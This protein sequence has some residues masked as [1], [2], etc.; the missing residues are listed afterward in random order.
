[1]FNDQFDKVGV[2]GLGIV[3]SR[4]AEVLRKADK[5]VYVWNRSPKPIPNFLSSPGELA[6]LADAIQIFVTNGEALIDVISKLKDSLTKR[7]LVVNNST[8]DPES[9]IKAAAIVGESGASFLDA[10]FTGSKVAAEKG[11]LVYYVGGEP[12]IAERAQPLLEVTA[13]EALF[14]GKVG[15]ASVLKIATN[16]ISAT[17]VHAL[18]EAYALTVR[19]GIEPEKLGEALELNA[20]SSV[21]T[22]MKLP[23]IINRD[24]DPHFSLKNMFKDA[25]F[26]MNLANQYQLD[27]PGI[28]T[29]ASVMFRTMQKGSGEE[30]YS[31]LAAN[32]Q[33]AEDESGE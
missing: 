23:T 6:Q 22:G 9:A 26:A 1:M 25:Q 4:V 20:C 10:P 28:S 15:D 3:G 24:Y 16:L 11:A 5:H 19:A 32:Y 2:I 8:V 30:D 12:K 33:D 17:T 13:K 7:H 27:L 31:V 21:L 29:T 14:V 18:S